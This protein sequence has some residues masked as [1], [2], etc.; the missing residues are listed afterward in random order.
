MLHCNYHLKKVF[1]NAT[2][3]LILD[4]HSNACCVNYCS[5]SLKWHFVGCVEFVRNVEE[6]NFIH[7]PCKPPHTALAVQTI[8][9][10]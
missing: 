9:L 7:L 8:I 5:L 1:P 2:L 4:H 6:I 10:R 3:Q